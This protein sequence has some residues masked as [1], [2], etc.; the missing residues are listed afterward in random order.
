MLKPDV[1]LVA[2]GQLSGTSVRSSCSAADGLRKWK[3]TPTVPT[4]LLF[5]CQLMV[6]PAIEWGVP[7]TTTTFT[8]WTACA[9]SGPRPPT[10]MT[11]PSAAASRERQT[12]PSTSAGADR[13]RAGLHLLLSVVAMARREILRSVIEVTNA[14]GSE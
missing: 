5:G 4:S 7:G 12:P 1:A 2:V 8:F 3:S 11:S 13:R 9:T 14:C 10:L 6:Y